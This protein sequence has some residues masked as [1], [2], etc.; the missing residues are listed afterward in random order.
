M[1]SGP[2]SGAY[3]AMK[4]NMAGGDPALGAEIR[5]VAQQ[6]MA[7]HHVIVVA[8]P[9]PIAGTEAYYVAYAQPVAG[10]PLRYF[11]MEKAMSQP[12]EAERAYVAE[13]RAGGMRIRHDDLPAVSLEAFV[14]HL[15]HELTQSPPMPATAPMSPLNSTGPTAYAARPVAPQKSGGSGKWVALGIVGVL[16]LGFLAYFVQ[17]RMEM[18]EWQERREARD[19]A[20]KEA[21]G[22]NKAARKRA[23]QRLDEIDKPYK[24]CLDTERA[25]AA[26][27]LELARSNRVLDARDVRPKDGDVLVGAKTYRMPTDK[28]PVALAFGGKGK[29]S[30]IPVS[31]WIA[32][33][34]SACKAPPKAHADL[35][36]EL[37]QIEPSEYASR[38]E[39]TYT[40]HT[41]KLD[42]LVESLDGFS[43]P[44]APAPS[45]IVVANE[46]CLST[47]V[48][49]YDN[50]GGGGLNPMGVD[51]KSFNCTSSLTW[52][53]MDGKRLASATARGSAHP[54]RQPPTTTATDLHG[55]NDTTWAKAS[56]N[57][58]DQLQ[59]KING[60]GGGAT[61]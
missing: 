20:A 54:G 22:A 43:Q 28:V 11:L 23:Q 19:A 60:W 59:K 47:V 17:R 27:A 16:G 34:A 10:G 38:R 12:G 51:L 57:A 37:S 58:A 56:Q 35:R 15:L 14:G 41:A 61:P 52:I 4:W 7:Q 30:W 48:A 26:K 8:L 36:S 32:R 33:D 25:R 53:S 18:A 6:P 49:H 46:A 24:T 9:T 31:R 29:T 55:I 2:Q 42:E 13:Y 5:I 50:V 39:E 45:A 44:A 1:I 3:F 40:T 21:K